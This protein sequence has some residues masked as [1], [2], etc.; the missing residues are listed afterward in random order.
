MSSFLDYLSSNYDDLLVQAA[1]HVQLVAI[2]IV[3]GTVVGVLLG[4]VAH[5]SSLLA[6]AIL[7]TE[8]VLLTIP[9][10][11]LFAL[12][13]PLVGIGPTPAIIALFLYSLLPI[14]RNT[15]AGLAQVDAAVVES[16]RGM[17]MGW[18]RRLV[19]IELPLAWP[20]I[21]TGIRVATLL[22]IGI[23]AVAALV[24]GPGL[25]QEIFS[26][27]RRL[28]SSGADQPI[29]GGTLLIVLIAFAFDVVYLVIGRL[30]TS[31]GLR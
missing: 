12:L 16:A 17:G 2:A 7:N 9:S 20:V 18:A 29:W 8:S 28:G 10:L 27:I 5:R 31:K 22:T 3:A 1:E 11:A 15:V 6:P 25:G 23:A 14:T 24:G 19:R 21:L 26:G 30:T 4:I 13:I